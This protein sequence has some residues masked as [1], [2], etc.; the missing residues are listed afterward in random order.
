MLKAPMLTS[1]V[2]L[3]S[4]EICYGYQVMVSAE[5]VNVPFS[6]LY[7]RFPTGKIVNRNRGL[8]LSL[9]LMDRFVRFAAPPLVIFDHSCKLFIYAA[10]RQPG[11]FAR[12][13][14]MVDRFHWDNHTSCASDFSVDAWPQHSAINSQVG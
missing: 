12:S 6:I 4:I 1:I 3:R 7:Q 2:L 5:S 14:F 13:M 8:D 10:T 9:V 11:F